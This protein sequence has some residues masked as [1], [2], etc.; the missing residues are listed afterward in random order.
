MNDYLVELFGGT[1]VN[2]SDIELYC[3]RKR[4][5]IYSIIETSKY[6]ELGVGYNLFGLKCCKNCKFLKSFNIY[7]YYFDIGYFNRLNR[8]RK[9][10]LLR[11]LSSI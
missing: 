3:I 6:I 1:I 9:I 10:R 4:H 8:K 5:R 11:G 7:Y 2:N